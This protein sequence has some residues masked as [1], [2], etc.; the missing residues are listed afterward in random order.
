MDVAEVIDVRCPG[1]PRRDGTCYPGKLLLRLRTT[2]QRPSYIH[3]D[4][5]IELL[6]YDCAKRKRRD[7]LPVRRVLH[8][9]NFLGELI[10]TLTE[11]DD[12]SR[13]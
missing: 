8:R 13:T 5:L 12:D 1:P 6:C 10:E 2:G 9:Y 11:L 7:G 3:P 4:N